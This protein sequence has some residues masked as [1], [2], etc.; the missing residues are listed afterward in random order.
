MVSLLRVMKNSAQC[1]VT[2]LL[3]ARGEHRSRIT[4]MN[5]EPV[6]HPLEVVGLHMG[7]STSVIPPV[8]YACIILYIV[9]YARTLA[10][11]LLH[12]GHPSP[13]PKH[14]RISHLVHSTDPRTLFVHRREPQLSQQGD[15]ICMPLAQPSLNPRLRA[16]TPA[17]APPTHLP[18]TLT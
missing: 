1:R 6:L 10:P 4:D 12:A 17:L 18:P 11:R 15:S 8:H 3:P 16:H 5:L 2:H 9:Q 13:K 7:E 14:A